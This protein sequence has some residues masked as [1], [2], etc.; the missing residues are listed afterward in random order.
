MAS[1]RL[2]R[3]SNTRRT[4]TSGAADGLGRRLRQ[5]RAKKGLT[6]RALAR[7]VDVSP[8]L[9]SQIELGAVTPSVGT[10]YRMTEQLGIALDEL[11]RDTTRANEKDSAHD[12]VPRV[13][14]IAYRP[15]DVIQR[16]GNRDVITLAGGVTW[17]RLT[18]GPDKDLEF[19]LI[20][21]EP[22]AESCP[23]DALI[24]HSAKAYVYGLSGRLGIQ[25][26][27]DEMELRPGESVA[28]DAQIPHRF[29]TVGKDPA[30]SLWSVLHVAADKPVQRRSRWPSGS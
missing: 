18:P 4:K 8:G 16:P 12:P 30:V 27:F 10:L 26:G 17:E 11:F 1:V 15:V 24:R 13:G 22:G 29:W 28:F 2:K 14:G 3:R 7:L 23:K 6:L 5:A 19:L 25:L 20:V 9:I 21:Y